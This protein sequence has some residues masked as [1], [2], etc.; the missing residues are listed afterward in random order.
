MA[1]PHVGSVFIVAH[2]VSVVVVAAC[3]IWFPDQGLYPGPLQWKHG[4]LTTEPP[5]KSQGNV[6]FMSSYILTCLH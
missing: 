6:I 4:V 1:V 2:E 3:G 5:G